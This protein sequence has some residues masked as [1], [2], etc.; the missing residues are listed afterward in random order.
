[1]RKDF[2]ST[3]LLALLRFLKFSP[4]KRRHLAL[5][6]I[7]VAVLLVSVSF[8]I[9]EVALSSPAL[10]ITVDGN[11][12]KALAS[13]Y[14]LDLSPEALKISS[15]GE[16]L[17][18]TFEGSNS[19]SKLEVQE[20]GDVVYKQLFDGTD[21][22]LYDKGDGNA[23]YDFYL[24]PG[25]N[26]QEL[27]M[28]MEGFSQAYIND[29]GDLVLPFDNS[30]IHHTKPV[31]YQMIEGKKSFVE[32]EF[33]LADGCVSFAVGDYE[34]SYGITI[35]P[36][37]YTTTSPIT[38]P[39]ATMACELRILNVT[40]SECVLSPIS[41]NIEATVEVEVEYE[42]APAGDIEVTLTGPV[43]GNSQQTY[44]PPG[45]GPG[46]DGTRTFTFRITPDGTNNHDID[47]EYENPSGCSDAND[48]YDSPDACTAIGN[49]VFE[50]T[51]RDGVQD[52]NENGIGNVNVHLFDATGTVVATTQTSNNGFYAF[53]AS[54]TNTAAATPGP[55][56]STNYFVVF[57][58]GGQFD[59]T[60]AYLN[61]GALEYALTLANQT[62]RDEDSDAVIEVS[63]GIAGGA[64]ASL[65][66]V[67]I[68]SG[69]ISTAIDTI[70]AGF[71]EVGCFLNIASATTGPCR[72]EG[73]QSVTALTVNVVYEASP[74]PG[75]N[76][77]IQAGGE[78]RSI[79][80]LPETNGVQTFTFDVPSNGGAG[81]I[82]VN[83]SNTTSCSTAGTYTTPASCVPA[84]TGLA[85]EVGGSV[86]IDYNA[87]GVMNGIETGIPS[88]T[89]KVYDDN[90]LL[91]GNATTNASG[92]WAVQGLTN[93]Q[94]YRVEF[95][96][97]PDV[98][99]P[100]L[101]G[102]EN[103][104][105]VQFTTAG[106]CTANLGLLDFV[107]NCSDP[108]PAMVTACY[109]HVNRPADPSV[110][111]FN[112]NSINSGSSRLSP[113]ASMPKATLATQAQVGNVH[114]F[115]Y[116]PRTQTLF[117]SAFVKGT[118]LPTSIGL[119]NGTGAIYSMD[120]NGAGT[121]S[122]FTTITGTG[123]STNAAA[124]VGKVGLGDIQINDAGDT[125]YAI[126]I[127]AKELAIVELNRTGSVLTA[128]AQ[129]AVSLPNPGADW[130][131]FAMGKYAGKIYVAMT[132][133]LAPLQSR[134]W[135]YNPSG[136]VFTAVLDIPYDY[137]RAVSTGYVGVNHALAPDW[138]APLPGAFNAGDGNRFQPWLVDI[139]FDRGSMVLGVRSR[140]GDMMPFANWTIGGDMLRAA[141]NDILA[142]TA[143]TL[144]EGGD[145]GGFRPTPS[146]VDPFTGIS[147]LNSTYLGPSGTNTG[148]Y[149]WGDDGAEGESTQG[150]VLQ[151]PGKS[152][153]ITTQVDGIGHNGQIG[154][155]RFSNTGGFVVKAGNIFSGYAIQNSV[156]KANG[157][158][159]MEDLCPPPP[160]QVGDYVWI[161][162]V[163][164]GQQDPSEDPAP[165][166][167]VFLFD[168]T[169]A[170]IANTTTSTEGAYEFNS[171]STPALTENST[172]YIVFGTD[173]VLEVGGKFYRRTFTDSAT[174]VDMPD[175]IDSDMR[176]GGGTDPV[177]IHDRLVICFRTNEFGQ[178][179]FDLDAGLMPFPAIGNLVWKD[180]N[181]DGTQDPG[182]P[183]IPGVL[184]RLLVDDGTGT[185]IPATDASGTVVPDQ[186]TNSDGEYLFDNLPEAT[187]RV[188]MTED[189]WTTGI[190]SPTGLLSG[191]I[192]T[193]GIGGDDQDNT[194]DNGDE[195]G[196][197]L[198]DSIQ[199]AP[200][201]LRLL[202]EPTDDG[203]G[204]PNTDISIDFGVSGYN[205]GNYVWV[206]AD[207]SGSLNANDGANP[208]LASIVVELLDENKAPVD[209]DLVTP[210]VQNRDTTDADGYYL[211]TGVPA[212]E[213][214]V[215]IP[216]SEFA[217]AGPLEDFYPSM[218]SLEEDNPDSN[219]DQNDNGLDPGDANYIDVPAT[220]GICTNVITLG[221]GNVEPTSSSTE[222]SN[223]DNDATDIEDNRSNITLDIGMWTPV[224]VGDLAWL[225]MNGDGEQDADEP[226]I[227]GVEL[228]LFLVDGAGG[229]VTP[230]NF[231]GGRVD[232]QTTDAAGH[233]CFDSLPP[234]EYV[235]RV[236]SVPQPWDPT[237]DGGDPDND[238]STD[239]NLILVGVDL[240]TRPVAAYSET[241]PTD[242]GDADANTNLSV[243][244]GF[245]GFDLGNYVWLDR[246]N[247]GDVTVND[248]TTPGISNVE[249]ELLTS[250]KTPFDFDPETPGV[251]NTTTTD[252]DGYYRF[253]GLP[254]GDFVV[255]LTASQFGAGQ[256][257]FD[258]F[259][260][261]GV[262]GEDDPNAG[263]SGGIDNDDN[264]LSP[265][266][267]GYP[268]SPLANGICSGVVTLG[269]GPVEPTGEP[270]LPAVAS[271]V[272]D[273]RS[274]LMVDFG[275]YTPVRVG[276]YVW[277]DTDADGEQDATEGPLGG[278]VLSLFVNDGTGNYVAA[279][280]AEG[281]AVTALTTAVDVGTYCFEDLP[282]GE[283]VVR[284]TT[285]PD[286]LD[287][288]SGGSDDPDTDAS[289]TDNNGQFNSTLGVVESL[290]IT[291]IVEDEPDTAGDGDDTDGNKTVDFGY[292]GFS[293]GNYVWTDAD[294]S[295]DV[296][297]GDGATPGIGGVTL[298]L[299]DAVGAP[300]DTDLLTAGVQST[301]VT[302]ADG[303]YQ[304]R[305]LKRGNY[306][307]KVLS[308]NFA[309]PLSGLHPSDGFADETDADAD[310]DQ[311][312][313]GLD[314]GDT[315]YPGPFG[316]NGVCSDVFYLGDLV[317]ERG[318]PSE[319]L[320]EAPTE[321]G[322][323]GND[324]TSL[325]DNRTN[326][327]LD[328]G[329]YGPVSIGD[330]VWNDYNVDGIQARD[331]TE[332]GIPGVELALERYNPVTGNYVP[333]FDI[334]DALIPNQFSGLDGTYS[335]A[336]L[337][338]GLYRVVAVEENWATGIFEPNNVDWGSA[339]STLGDGADDQNPDDDNAGPDFQ[340][341]PPGGVKTDSIQLTWQGELAPNINRDPSI[342]LGFFRGLALGNRVF[343]DLDNNNQHDLTSEAG[344]D[345]VMVVLYD[346]NAAGQPT[347]PVD[348]Q[349]TQAGGYYLFTLLPPG[350]Y[351]VM[352][353]GHQFAPDSVLFGYHSTGV[354]MSNIGSL[355]ETAA[356]DPDD[357]AGAGVDL[358]D[359]GNKIVAPFSPFVGAVMSDAIT[360]SPDNPRE[361]ENEP[362]PTPEPPFDNPSPD[363]LTNETV[364]FG[365]YKTKVSNIV[366][367][368]DQDGIYEPGTESGIPNINLQL[369]AANGITPIK[370]GPDGLLGSFDDN[371]PGGILTNADG[372]YCFANLPEGD[373]VIKAS[374]PQGY[375]SS[376]GTQGHE[377]GPYELAPDVDDQV[378]NDDN[379]EVGTGFN[380]GYIVSKV[381]TQ[382]AGNEVDSDPLT[383]ITEDST[384]DF[385][386]YEIYSVGNQVWFDTD[387]NANIDI[388]EQ[389]VSKV[390][391]RL[392]QA[393]AAGLPDTLVEVTTTDNDGFYLFT[394]LDSGEYV[395]VL[396][397]SN[398]DV[399]GP[400]E[401]YYSSLASLDGTGVYAETAAPDPDAPDTDEDDNGSLY[402]A[403][404]TPVPGQDSVMSLAISLGSDGNDEL[405]AELVTSLTD[406]ALD[407]NSNYGVDFGFYQNCLGNLVFEDLNNDGEKSA[408]EIGLADIG[409]QLF[410]ADG[411]TEIPVGPDG[412]LGT[413]DDA[414]GG[415]ATDPS[416]LYKFGGL[417]DGDYIVKVDVPFGYAS[418]TGVNGQPTGPY[419]PG[420]DPR[421]N[422]DDDDNSTELIETT[423]AADTFAITTI[424]TLR[425]GSTG[426]LGNNILDY[427]TGITTDPTVDVGL[428]PTFSL[429]NQVWY[430]VD[431]S[432]TKEATE[433]GIAGVCV[434][435]YEADAQGRPTGDT[436]ATDLTDAAGFYRFDGLVPG[437]YIVALP[438]SNFDT[439][440]PLDTYHSSAT[441]VDNT[442]TFSEVTAAAPNN[443]AD[444]DD[445]GTLLK[446]VTSPF[447]GYILSQTVTLDWSPGQEPEGEDPVDGTPEDTR[448]DQNNYTVDFG[449]YRADVG[450]LVFDDENNSGTV[451][452]T[453][454]GY[455][456]GVTMKI[457]AADGTTEV[458]VGPDGIYGTDDDALGG[459]TSGA[460]GEYLFGGLPEGEYVIKL[461]LPAGYVSSSGTNASQSG[462]Y[463]AALDADDNI[464]NDDNG[465]QADPTQG[466]V[467]SLPVFLD[468][469]DLGA[470]NLNNIDPTTG[471]TTDST[472]DF[473]IYETHS[474]GNIVWYDT[475]NDASKTAA[476]TGIDSV[477]M[478]LYQVDPVSGTE[479][480]ID[481]D[482]TQNG[483]FYCFSYLAPYYDYRVV[484]PTANFD[485]ELDG[486][487]SSSTTKD[488]AAGFTETAALDPD[489]NTDNDDNGTTDVA[490]G[491]NFFDGAVQSGVIT[492]GD[493]EPIN[494]DVTNRPDKYDPAL[495]ENS[496]L[497]LDFGFYRAKM[498]NLVFDDMLN[499][500]TYDGGTIDAPLAGAEV[501]LYAA[502]GTTAIPV[503]A[504]GTW[505]TA[506][507]GAAPV[508]TDG[509]GI[510]RF[511]DLPEGDYIIKVTPPDDY[512]SSTGTNGSPTGPFETAPDPDAV[513]TDNDDNGTEEDRAT[514]VIATS[515]ISL[516][517]GTEPAEDPTTG[518]A[519]D[520]WIDFALFIPKSIGNLVWNDD[521][522][523]EILESTSNDGIYQDSTET[524]IADVTMSIYADADS[525]GIADSATPIATDVTDLGGYYLFDYLACG[526]YIVKVDASNF[527]PGNPLVGG[528]S[529]TV[530][531]ADP[532]DD[533]DN[534]DNGIDD[535]VSG[536]QLSWNYATNGVCSGTIYL[537]HDD[538]PE[539][540]SPLDPTDLN[541]GDGVPEDNNANM[542]VDFS[543]VLPVAT[544]GNLVWE[545]LNKDGL[546]DASEPLV[547]G[548]EVT[549]YRY[550]PAD[551]SS[552]EV[553]RDTTDADGDYRF[554][555][556][557]S[558]RQYYVQFEK[559]SLPTD[560]ILTQKD[561]NGNNPAPLQDSI[562]SDAHPVTGL[563]IPT[564]L[565]PMESDTSWDAGIYKPLAE[566]G[567]L[568]WY[569]ND[570]DG[571]QD[572]TGEPGVPGVIV[573][574][575]NT[576]GDTLETDVTDPDGLY[577]F[578]DVNPGDYKVAFDLSTIPT[579]YVVS[580]QN[581]GVTDASDSDASPVDGCTQVT[582]LI[583]DEIDT[584]W[585]MGIYLPPASIG[586]VVWYDNNRD[587]IQD[588]GEDGVE[589]VKVYLLDAAGSRIDSMLTDANGLYGFDEL[590]PAD[591]AIE[592]NLSTLPTDYV[593]TTQDQ[594]GNDAKDSDADPVSGK[595]INTTLD[596]GEDDITWDMGIYLPAAALGD[597][598]WY[599]DNR[600]GIQDAGEMGVPGVIVQLLD[601]TDNNKVIK[602]DTT[603]AN[604]KYF[605]EGLNAGD[606][607]VYFD[608]L[609]ADYVVSPQNQGTNDSLNSD[610]DVATRLTTTITLDAGETDSTWDMGI[611]QPPASLGD[612]VWLDE[613]G[614]GEKDANEPGVPF[615]KVCLLDD[616]GNRID[617][618]VTD[619]SGLYDFDTLDPG[620]Y[621]VEFKLPPGYAFSPKD[622]TGD[623]TN[624]SDPDPVT[625]ITPPT[626]LDPLENDPTL[627]AG[628]YLPAG[629]G[630]YTWVDEDG[631]G[632]QDAGEVGINGVKVIL[633]DA[634]GSK[635]DST[636]TANNGINDGYYAF[637]DL[638]PGDY[639]V[640]FGE[641]VNYERSAQNNTAAK[642]PMDSDADQT[643]GETGTISL[644]SGEFDPT[645][646][647][648][649]WQPASLGDFVWLDE[650]GDGKQD[651]TEAGVPNVKVCL[652]DDQGNQVD[653]TFTDAAG[654]YQFDDLAPD[655]YAVAFKLPAGYEISPKDN[656]GD[657]TNDSD[658]D[659]VT[660]VTP[661][662]SL[663]PN[664][665]DSTFDAGIY[666]P[667]GLGDYVWNDEDRDGVQ[668]LGELGINGVKVILKD[669]NGVKLDS[670]TTANN[671]TNDGYYV[672]AGLEPGDYEVCFDAPDGYVPTVQNNT[673]GDDPSD[674]DMD[675]VTQS[676]D[677]INLTSN[678]FDPTNDAGYYL[679]A[680]L[681]DRVW[682]DQDGNGTQDAGEP[683]VEDVF[684]ALYSNQNVLIARDTTDAN[685]AYGF[686]DLFAG[687]Y[688]VTFDISAQPV[689][690][691]LVNPMEG[692]D[693]EVD[694]NPD[695]IT[696]RT[697][698][699]TLDPGENDSTIDA[700]L[701]ELAGLGDLV[702]KD[703]NGDGAQDANEPGEADVIAVLYDTDNNEVSR[704]T[705]DANGEYFFEG[706]YPG[707]YYVVFDISDLPEGCDYSP[708]DNTPND[709]DDSD[710]D[711]TG[712]TPVVSLEPGEQDSTVD[713]GLLPLA[714]LGDYV[715]KD[716]DGDGEQDA[717]EP[718]VEDVYVALY[719]DQNT[720]VDRDTTDANGA[721]GFEN[722]YPGDYY[723]VFDLT[724]QPANCDYTNPN[725]SGDPK[726][727]SD[728]DPI[729]GRTPNTT[730]EAGE[731]DSTIDAGLIPLA[732]LGDLVWNDVNRNGIQ[733][734]GE[735][736]I[737][738]VKVYLLD[739]NGIRLDS[740]DT[741]ALGNYC[742]FNLQPGD[743]FVV[744]FETPTGFVPSPPN[745]TP[746]DSMDSDPDPVTGQTPPVVLT[747]GENNP[748]VD[749]GF[750]DRFDLALRKRRA[751]SQSF[752]VSPGDMVDFTVTIFNQGTVVARNIEVTDYLPLNTTLSDNDWTDNGDSTA[753]YT[754]A[755]P[756]APGDSA[757]VDVTI[758]LSPFFSDTMFLNFAE[759]S[760]ATDDDLNPRDDDDGDFDDDPDNDGPFVNNEIYSAP[761]IDEDNHDPAD[762]IM[763]NQACV[764]SCDM[765]D[766]GVGQYSFLFTGGAY[767][768]VSPRYSYVNGSGQ[769]D[770]YLNNSIHLTGT[771][772]ND[773]DPTL[774]WEIDV[775]LVNGRNWG[776]WSALGRSYK[777]GPGVQP[778]L[779]QT[780]DFF[781]LDASRSR[782][783]GAGSLMGDTLSLT[784]MPSS[785]RHGFQYGQGANAQDSD[786]GLSGWF[787]FS[788]K[789][790]TYAGTGDFITDLNNCSV[791]NAAPK[792]MAIATLLEGAF[793]QATGEMRT[794]LN[795][796]NL[797]PL[798]Q[799]FNQ[800]PWN[801][802]GTEAVSIIP[803]DSIVDW[804]LVEVRDAIDPRIVL[805][806]QA[807]FVQKNGEVVT[808]DGYSLM[809][810]PTVSSFYLSVTH[811]N[812]LSAMS[813]SP[814][815]L[816]NNRYFADLTAIG[817]LYVNP[818]EPGAPAA[819]V[820]GRMVLLQGDQS[821][822]DQINSLDLGG[823][824]TNYFSAGMRTADVNLDG[825]T[826]SLDVVRAMQN[827]FRRSHT[828]R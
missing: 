286:G 147:G 372:E 666:I 167:P 366:W 541:G 523:K 85:D 336:N 413:D 425:A 131:P 174:T 482:S 228:E 181:G 292:V 242:D 103:G 613:D 769:I 118:P 721:Y 586:D 634:T 748:T 445:N 324:G 384:A 412:V 444:A 782:L 388:V 492:L 631:N 231:L 789:A 110:I 612:L 798:S 808:T 382:D 255:R 558:N 367:E 601:P 92:S 116:D 296:T 71:F 177:S 347:A 628:I 262:N 165:L 592:F 692:N 512:I 2:L 84:C 822:D 7:T 279:V 611:N 614:D 730:L 500:G 38:A 363:F 48:N 796:T 568:V 763:V 543:F 30:L 148:E 230:E 95:T 260:S 141:G 665:N 31:S 650:N 423:P 485:E 795:T 540:E 591:Y 10:S 754:F 476:D 656:T 332:P 16:A 458:P 136:N 726:T 188:V 341:N 247:S 33:V 374:I 235:V 238:D 735:P 114:S 394:W 694:S 226:A 58:G 166:V 334:L 812:H 325:D 314:I 632:V 392:Y 143:W 685:G 352:I 216:A 520:P 761:P 741:D 81:N 66:Y 154:V 360:L 69:A 749:A 664:E 415:I 152:E 39:Q 478:E 328:F 375:T 635:L 202:R 491:G 783:V 724:A 755:G 662:T 338:P 660:G 729:T 330:T 657:D 432:S 272:P 800:A 349:K 780:W 78:T 548:I 115:S 211:F 259:P 606:Y 129:T 824:M 599:D 794:T 446:D 696:G 768:G 649:Y 299:C 49:Y 817:S 281:A 144:E 736:G 702:W 468:P 291:L 496:N 101:K 172:Y 362:D 781:E 333:A 407:R 639:V 176:L 385:G 621:S 229:L 743:P 319:P 159:G 566:I 640:C 756:L 515:V 609:P 557:P 620:T 195:D 311:N 387:N 94:A 117:A 310:G 572:P 218:G 627:D 402:L 317:S 580:P 739:Q 419:E 327:T 416:G 364:D 744:G 495:D 409:V 699:V 771:V 708:Q 201:V 306:K 671:G 21:L 767:P 198:P 544:F 124:D 227:P 462:P 622:N 3:S 376:S 128:G 510:Y 214:I 655:D 162:D 14:A 304:F 717:T 122:L 471:I 308:T 298:Q 790:G 574:L 677:I 168:D 449:F 386:M 751:A 719:D 189:N 54:N 442:F 426:D 261:N 356:L 610:A 5:G 706:L 209:I 153:V 466:D 530:T 395:V 331:A 155:S 377:N 472:V 199:S 473:G 578:I 815:S 193:R 142:P 249:I 86:F 27:C 720:L 297:P 337:A 517:P 467:A 91:V 668:D 559:T 411:T 369:F 243:D 633:K 626:N 728:P 191:F 22:H 647:A 487:Y 643:T 712:K 560:Y 554:V 597:C 618:T 807:G 139:T 680:S 207:N 239:N 542:T 645:N 157:L 448:D 276:D 60:T 777:I 762:P 441:T 687:N 483:G 213:Y 703:L 555:E 550:N 205:L 565:S 345:N 497:T 571:L 738:D 61:I 293:V 146:N 439:G 335:F 758:M 481:T 570:R 236:V 821:S 525:N 806:R 284:V 289:N 802:A 197:I 11:N 68:T 760:G 151:I 268:G 673:V 422:E 505:G 300:V 219:G 378:D 674:N 295:G 648:G 326:L 241:E 514:R 383:G 581:Q 52:N 455:P 121:P 811:R 104:G 397:A 13:T 34:P 588:V 451:D 661:N 365:F 556:L 112:F 358:D 361:P 521:D 273:N 644:M 182:E 787:N 440:K 137:R 266:S 180:L 501:R 408:T 379:G 636:T 29:D 245:V 250:A 722:L 709:D 404:A 545:D 773:T 828:P 786:F 513:Q 25:K 686:D 434:S 9:R 793:D 339:M 595:T 805:S 373:Y 454:A 396:P 371:F 593:V 723:V 98:L 267:T 93:G 8:F 470:N 688:Y 271:T 684:V 65:P 526:A 410:A 564:L 370:T 215:R 582:N 348:T 538:E 461:E 623:D 776:D 288:T 553:S 140:V 171:T 108:N 64:F 50:D 576:N 701:V 57:G 493:T 45:S 818:A 105:I 563:T 477:R 316:A 265:A 697:P 222:D 589:D 683:G 263:T 37:V 106:T 32:S 120:L 596:P 707:D 629:L 765:D 307:L 779:Y 679:P 196:T 813:A 675:P 264:G 178:N 355:Q 585:D 429:G 490:G 667:A 519:D 522:G 390:E 185:F 100:T 206:D 1:M 575:L 393:D 604:G 234:G 417:P 224:K 17:S 210:G 282:P 303:F 414:T 113:V 528:I 424:D 149:Y 244:I 320:G 561:A 784:H 56:P 4:H 583:A 602:I 459:I 138:N 753:T 391:V 819:L 498:G 344:V 508:I 457:C 567:D 764:T 814:V 97:Y 309:G 435:L 12:A 401:G 283:Y 233:Y 53:D 342:D 770:R 322:I 506:D 329:F 208:G 691:V 447:D 529:S 368:D 150:G 62:T 774:R 791:C 810:I 825:V 503:G 625:G 134:I 389:G 704:D 232:N 616:L 312:D 745:A 433:L 123:A 732:K 80:I 179:I 302:N 354:T 494:E 785:F 600:D 827:Y 381:F 727:D 109:A 212:G 55:S 301:T 220:A 40:V 746:N 608:Q 747:P 678:E 431:N 46:T 676:T 509:T 200:I 652:L 184:M 421:D 47:V 605:F 87:D 637:T 750:Y 651:P 705:T 681:G 28:K 399:G 641:A 803:H 663:D 531:E 552:V 254:S 305:G 711:P 340:V 75:E 51:D 258:H 240:Q 547:A 82:T 689:A 274:N 158:G 669:G 350:E 170:Q 658:P 731:K 624:D 277:L 653:S 398:F 682:K 90:N 403:G 26:P 801:Y 742:F 186:P 164:N 23:G 145:A 73:G 579:D 766:W 418:S 772:A 15:E 323:A 59:A 237:V 775:W 537:D 132:K 590:V 427:N 315:G 792:G 809:P 357:V 67:E 436:I 353:P 76:L 573:Y 18:M 489:N 346:A 6:G 270:N 127:T 183:G 804:V 190:F 253:R 41:G 405:L 532:N 690:C 713:A 484:I 607:V 797:L 475:D 536:S 290:P 343:F 734:A 77:V 175:G 257:L 816:T 169:G 670:T 119:P 280:D 646:D 251:Q 504:D 126:N 133:S 516:D 248:G 823:V 187:Y 642:D 380:T 36:K 584:R 430:D 130:F 88:V 820:G 733:D 217:V 693:P 406:P 577:R 752:V 246:D 156:G 161:D 788:N 204:N 488:A 465:T 72:F 192:G 96:G 534:N 107:Y 826:N 321:S 194:D 698:I 464:D 203:D 799:P 499:D 160:I 400:L 275:L 551:G 24:E 463:E 603:D 443:N 587:G 533:I 318:A 285:G 535:L 630:D 480:Q 617:S 221:P 615:V 740:V 438:D 757:K 223:F 437:D 654:L 420:T 456:A 527:A 715:W 638:A 111:R 89:I 35:D 359:N 452:G 428:I 70:D 598:V 173:S 19:D 518:T 479:T 718:G 43:I 619:A 778:T 278:V 79:S 695:P 252:A 294:G 453:E 594:P 737:K 460:A 507:D 486:Y 716:L 20:N 469:G 450:N 549:L 474:L 524:P 759:I 546:Q 659:P 672:F 83:F 125:L 313:N 74:R 710:V 725:T 225:D 256:P 42:D 569:D 502:D 135:E 287:P 63:G 511:C 351:V 700:G 99:Y 102:A 44:N 269:S 163:T 539:G 714:S 562:D